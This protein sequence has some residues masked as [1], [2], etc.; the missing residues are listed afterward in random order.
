MTYFAAASTAAQRG[1]GEEDED[2]GCFVI[3]DSVDFEGTDAEIEA[4]IDAILAGLSEEEQ[5]ALFTPVCTDHDMYE[6]ACITQCENVIGFT[7]CNE[8]E[9][10]D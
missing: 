3:F 10:K 8:D 7:L 2:C 1:G 9:L 5:K 4:Q 6:N